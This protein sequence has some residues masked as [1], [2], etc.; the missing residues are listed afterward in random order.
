MKVAVIKLG[1]RISFNAKDT[2]GGNGEARSIVKMLKTGG[3]DVHIFTKILA[4]DNLIEDYSWHNLSDDIDTSEMDALVILNGAVNFFGGA[5]DREQLMNY[6]IINHFKGPVFYTLCDP[7]LTLKQVW[8]S[9][10]KKDWA[11]NWSESSLLITREDIVFLSQPWDTDKVKAKLGKNEV[12]PKAIIHFPFEQFPCMNEMLSENPT[13]L[14]DLSYGGTMRG[15][16]RAKKMVKFYFDH[17]VDLAVEMF[18]KI[19]E[20]DFNPKLIAGLHQPEFTGP[21]QYNDMLPKMNKSLSHCVIG[22]PWYETINDIPQRLYESVYS[23]VIT[24]VDADMDKIRRVWSRDKELGDF[25]Y[26]QTRAELSEK[27]QLIKTDSTLRTQVLESQIKAVNFDAQSYCGGFVKLLV[28][29]IT[30]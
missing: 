25:L 13:P 27:I 11:S 15:G 2:S 18:G 3:A 8:P 10:E 26:V 14:V 9:V 23:N 19:E 7:A 24:F 6:V 5:E 29:Q 30:N 20:K 28:D 1:A 12:I 16:R 21:V 22:D 4:K 17:P